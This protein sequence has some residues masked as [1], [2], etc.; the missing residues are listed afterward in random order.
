MLFNYLLVLS[1]LSTI[2][3]SNVFAFVKMNKRNTV[4]II[5]KCKNGIKI[6]NMIEIPNYQKF[7][8]NFQKNWNF[9]ENITSVL[10]IPPARPISPEQ[11]AL[12]FI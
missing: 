5:K 4:K 6:P 12:L 7:K 10:R 11:V 1:L 9:T 3:S 8:E 2:S